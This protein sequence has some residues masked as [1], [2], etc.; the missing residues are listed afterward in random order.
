MAY[1]NNNIYL[2]NERFLYKYDLSTNSLDK[3][4]ETNA[5]SMGWEGKKIAVAGNT[6]H[7]VGSASYIHKIDATTLQE[8]SR[9]GVSVPPYRPYHKSHIRYY[10][11]NIYTLG[12]LSP[13]GD[14]IGIAVNGGKF[15]AGQ[16][17]TRSQGC[18]VFRYGRYY[19]DEL[20]VAECL[21]LHGLHVFAHF[22]ELFPQAQLVLLQALHQSLP[23]PPAL[24]I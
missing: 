23:S 2:Y 10:N 13:G 17:N 18:Y 9:S 12:S 6:I 21:F 8:I 15:G 22:L 20:I 1:G 5:A 4:V 24:E 14:N 11:G 7:L 3:Q 19:A 16:C